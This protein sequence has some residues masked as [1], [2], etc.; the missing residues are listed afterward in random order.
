VKAVVIGSGPNGFAGAI[1]RAGTGLSTWSCTRSRRHWA[2]TRSS[3]SEATA[4][5]SRLIRRSLVTEAGA[6]SAQHR[7]PLPA[8]VGRS[9]SPRGV[10]LRSDTQPGS[11]R[12]RGRVRRLRLQVRRA[13]GDPGRSGA[14]AAR[15]ARLERRHQ[16]RG[17]R[18]LGAPPRRV[19][20][21]IRGQWPR[22]LSLLPLRDISS[23]NSS[24]TIH[25]ATAISTPPS[26]TT[27]ADRVVAQ[28][29]GPFI[30]KGLLSL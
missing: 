9:S 22:R 12:D 3:R 26:L 17:R 24:E 4:R 15:S 11:G 2:A 29:A 27:D 20:A 1:E 30:Q 14:R 8:P 7:A 21:G 19:V 6:G 13:D 10:R 23:H 16:H 5:F 25:G 28:G 18:Q